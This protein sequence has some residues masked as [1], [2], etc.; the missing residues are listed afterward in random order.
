MTAAGNALAGQRLTAAGLQAV[1]PVAA[2][3]N[4]NESVTSS[5]A[6]Q[7][8]NALL[9]PLQANAVYYFR[10]FFGYTGGTQ[11]SSDIKFGFTIPSGASMTWTRDGIT[12]AGV[13]PVLVFNTTTAASTLG[14]NGTGSDEAGTVEGT[15]TTGGTAGNLQ[16]Q[17]AQNTSSTTATTVLAGSSLQAWQIQ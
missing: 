11:G 1:A 2:F 3:K 9:I 15:V 14:T 4:A 8:D 12:T 10:M 6:L 7:N 5:T 17:W 13:R 16:L